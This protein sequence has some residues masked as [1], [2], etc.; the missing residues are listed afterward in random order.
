MNQPVV[1]ACPAFCVHHENINDDAD[2]PATLS[3]Q[4]HENTVEFRYHRPLSLR[5]ERFDVPGKEPE[6]SIFLYPDSGLVQLTLEEARQL[7]AEM[8]GRI[9]QAD[10]DRRS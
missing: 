3:H 8:T 7:N 1:H 9:E 10:A 5:L 2:K 6:Y 4:G